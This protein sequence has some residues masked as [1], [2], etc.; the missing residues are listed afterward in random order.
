MTIIV[1][2][3]PNIGDSLASYDPSTRSWRTLQACFTE[4][5]SEYL[6]TFP[7]AGFVRNGNLYRLRPLVRRI[8]ATESFWWL[9][10]TVADSKNNGNLSRFSRPKG[11]GGLNGQIGGPVNPKWAEWL[12]G[13]P[14]GWTDLSG[15]EG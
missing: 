2:S 1:G 7:R 5:S 8:S 15:S 3:G 9:T 10:P 4:E 14:E 6:A 13:L 11:L 12:M